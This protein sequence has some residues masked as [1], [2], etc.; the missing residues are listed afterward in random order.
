MTTITLENPRDLLKDA[1]SS[2]AYGKMIED[3][4]GNCGPILQVID[5]AMKKCVGF[6]PIELI[7]K[8]VS[9]D[10]NGVDEL[11][12]NWQ[13]TGLAVTAIGHN[14]SAIAAAVP[15]V[16]RAPAAT[17]AKTKLEKHAEAHKR[18]GT[19]C[20][21]MSRQLGNMLKATEEVVSACCG[22]LGLI[23]EWVVTLS[24]AK[25]AKEVL[26]G[27]SGVRRAIRLINQAIDLIKSLGKLIP[28]LSAACGTMAT[29]LSACNVILSFGVSSINSE[30]GHHI[31]DTSQA[32][33][34]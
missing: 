26:T 18:Q 10:F 13:N 5:W 2:D 34:K 33:F 22:L 15:D 27:G 30:G 24:M 31:D 6:S 20:G 21:L 17:R 29:V 4:K 11:K 32:G 28:A 7:M 23:E 8:P 14:Y 3:A 12:T 25:L 1:P 9:G 19:A 16:W